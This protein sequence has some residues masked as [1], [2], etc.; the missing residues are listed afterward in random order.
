VSRLLVT[1]EP[2]ELEKQPVE[3]QDYRK[4]THHFKGMY[5]IT[6]KLVKKS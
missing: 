6:L 3:V 5:G 1:N 2:V 4:N